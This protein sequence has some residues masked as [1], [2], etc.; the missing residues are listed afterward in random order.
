MSRTDTHKP[1]EFDPGQYEFVGCMDRGSARE[2]DPGYCDLEVIIAYERA[3]HDDAW[4]GSTGPFPDYD[5]ARRYLDE[6]M[7]GEF[8][9]HDGHY[10]DRQGCDHCGQH[11]I[12]N[13]S[14]YL[15]VP[16]REL[17]T[18]G[19]QC[20]DRFTAASR[21]ELAARQRVKQERARRERE[22]AVQTWL[23][24]E[25]H[26]LQA[27]LLR[28]A[29]LRKAA[30]DALEYSDADQWRGQA[31]QLESTQHRQA[32]EA[33]GAKRRE[34]HEY[35]VAEVEG[36]GNYG[37]NGFLHDILSKLNKYGSLSEKQVDAV[38]RGKQRDI[39]R[40]ARR[41]EER[42]DEPEPSPVLE[43]K[44]VKVTGKILSVKWKESQFGGALKMLVLDDRGFKVWGTVPGSMQEGDGGTDD[45]LRGHR[46]TF[47]AGQLEKSRDDETFGFFKRPRGGKVLDPYHKPPPTDEELAE[48]E[49]IAR[50]H[51]E[52][53][54][55][56][57]LAAR[58]EEGDILAARM[59][60]ERRD[61]VGAHT[62]WLCKCGHT[63]PTRRGCCE[64]ALYGT[65][66][67]KHNLLKDAVLLENDAAPAAEGV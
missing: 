45:E 31:D 52:Q 46:C 14:T 60:F 59:F 30:E 6:R 2:D 4:V 55:T 54:G 49:R 34:A 51:K 53:W 27:D 18:V 66:N 25:V 35:L 8:R 62:H 9:A 3:G 7:P 36:K 37:W 11:N 56:G 67:D 15:H 33:E 21:E 40:A 63:N 23:H 47:I 16:T 43:G 42:K 44:S 22:L 48:A 38:L 61:R 29:Q 13:F 24:P 65:D 12:R 41:E 26:V 28:A 19:W 57:E 58:G 20:A 39:E 64:R 32:L 5:G 1:S 17:V 10:L 50:G